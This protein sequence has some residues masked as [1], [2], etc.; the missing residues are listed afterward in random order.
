MI[1]WYDAPDKREG[2]TWL[3]NP[4]EVWGSPRLAS[5]AAQWGGIACS[6]AGDGIHSQFFRFRI[7][8]FTPS[9]LTSVH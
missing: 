6:V 8:A 5:I 7:L 9:L 4:L 3:E 2:V 1:Y